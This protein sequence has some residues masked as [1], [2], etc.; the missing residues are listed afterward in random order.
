MGSCSASFGNT[1]QVCLGNDTARSGRDLPM[2]VSNQESA[3]Q[4]RTQFNLIW[5]V[6]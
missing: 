2:S 5:A 6:P 3:L 1:G 4:T